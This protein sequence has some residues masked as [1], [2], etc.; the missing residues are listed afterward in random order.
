MA[1]PVYLLHTRLNGVEVLVWSLYSVSEM[2]P[3][4]TLNVPIIEIEI[5]PD[6]FC[7][8][9]FTGDLYCTSNIGLGPEMLGSMQI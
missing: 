3:Q 4:D 7:T 8:H 2:C 1:L 6:R 9:S 5:H